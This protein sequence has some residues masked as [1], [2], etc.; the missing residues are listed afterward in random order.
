MHTYK[1]DQYTY[2]YLSINH[3]TALF[4]TLTILMLCLHVCPQPAG[5]ASLERALGTLILVLVLLPLHTA[6]GAAKIVQ[7]FA[8]FEK[9][10]HES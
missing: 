9:K 1:T 7:I 2:S 4:V 8:C 10:M 6:A 5:P 3:C